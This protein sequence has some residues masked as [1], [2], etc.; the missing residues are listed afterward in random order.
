VHACLPRSAGGKPDGALNVE[1]APACQ[2]GCFVALL[3]ALPSVHPPQ[4]VHL[5]LKG[6]VLREVA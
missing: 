6:E 5:T 2:K 4:V 3:A 1:A